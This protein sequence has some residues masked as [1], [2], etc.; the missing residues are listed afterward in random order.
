VLVLELR[1]GAVL[2]DAAVTQAL[3]GR[4]ARWWHPDAI[5]RVPRM[6]LAATGKIDKAAL[7]RADRGMAGEVA[8]GP[9]SDA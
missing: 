1:P 4:I 2:A 5:V 8:H 9:P 7:R 6:P 3:D